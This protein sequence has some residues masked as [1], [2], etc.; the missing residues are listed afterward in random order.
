M[1]MHADIRVGIGFGVALIIL[2]FLGYFSFRNNQNFISSRLSIFNSTM[3]LNNIEQ[4][5]S[6]ANLAEEIVA[7]YVITEDP[8]F[9]KSYDNAL[10]AAAEHYQNLRELTV[11]NRNFQIMLDSF[12]NVGGRKLAIHRKILNESAADHLKGKELIN[13][14]V[15]IRS[16]IEVNNIIA[17][18]RKEENKVLSAKIQISTDNIEKFQLTFILLM[19][20]IVLILI[21]VLYV[22]NAS[23][24]AR[25]MAD[26]K[27]KQINF[28]L[29]AFTYSVSHDLRAPLRSIRGF[30][31]V[32]RD[33]FGPTMNEE[34]N[35][36]LG[37][38]MKN[39]SRM[40]QLIDDLLDFSRMGRKAL[41]FSNINTQQ[42]VKEVM[43][44]LMINMKREVIW[45]IAPLPNLMGDFS[46]IKQVWVNLI[47]NAIKYSINTPVTKVQ[48]GV[49]K[50]G[51][52]V[53][54]YVKDNGVGFD[55]KYSDKLFKVFQ[56]LHNAKEFEGTGVGLALVHRI[57]TKHNGKVWANAR[58]NEGATFFF[59]LHNP[60]L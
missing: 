22:I 10:K 37:I 15:N 57:I 34:G 7:K 47:S 40:G 48:I 44:E 41:T 11:T 55:E 38:V 13:G 28:E 46:M 25:L 9:L 5:Q 21:V 42:L 20:T 36:L 51:G 39:A 17:T 27:T 4:T 59:Y 19:M 30:T 31:E 52:N 24:K 43:Q 33:E 16:T 3:V 58:P 26:E 35:R 18:M 60:T 29:E 12:A 23:F 1:K 45:E 32:L 54:F 49:H 6:T 14:D 8:S 56:R 2:L 53:I 50:E